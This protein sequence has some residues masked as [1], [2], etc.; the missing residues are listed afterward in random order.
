MSYRAEV[1][2][3]VRKEWSTKIDELNRVAEELR[4]KLRRSEDSRYQ[5]AYQ[6]EDIVKNSGLKTGIDSSLRDIKEEDFDAILPALQIELNKRLV[7]AYHFDEMMKA[8]HSNETVLG[9]WKQ[10]VM[11]LRLCGFDKEETK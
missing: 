3:K 11:T 6:L 8:V 7:Q 10:F 1:E 2:E 9:S 4:T 5:L